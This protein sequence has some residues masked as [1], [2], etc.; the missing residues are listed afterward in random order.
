MGKITN[1][2]IFPH[3]LCSS[4]S[5]LLSHLIFVS[6]PWQG[7]IAISIQL[8][9][10]LLN[11]SRHIWPR[12]H[13]TKSWYNVLHM[14][15]TLGT[16]SKI[17]PLFFR[18]GNKVNDSLIK[19]KEVHQLSKTMVHKVCATANNKGVAKTP[20]PTKKK[21]QITITQKSLLH[22]MFRQ[23]AGYPIGFP[24]NM[25]KWHRNPVYKSQNIASCLEV[26]QILYFNF[27]YQ[28]VSTHLKFLSLILRTQIYGKLNCLIK[29]I[30]GKNPLWK[31]TNE[32]RYIA[33]IQW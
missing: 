16:K 7:T 1:D 8:W 30:L 25:Y 19:R 24:P 12:W 2:F 21:K 13:S 31:A 33:S 20:N 17:L 14:K 5:N 10:Y 26:T 28:H 3:H 22:S 4:L 18:N 27:L 15:S 23:V 32:M 29:K 11:V 9:L 6:I